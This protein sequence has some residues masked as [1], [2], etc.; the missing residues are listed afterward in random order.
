[1][2]INMKFKNN[3][4]CCKRL[5]SAPVIVLLLFTLFFDL[6]AVAQSSGKDAPLARISSDKVYKLKALLLGRI[7][8]HVDWVGAGGLNNSSPSFVLS[9]I[10]K[11]PFDKWLDTIYSARKKIKNKDVQ[12]RYIKKVEEIG[13]SHILFIAEMS[14]KELT[15][16]LDYTK[17]KPILTIADTEGYSKRGVHINILETM[18]S[19]GKFFRLEINEADAR[20]AGIV[21]RKSMLEAAN[22][23]NINPYN[24]EQEKA[25]RLEQAIQ[26]VQWTDEKTSR[27]FKIAVMG[28]NPIF[29]QLN[30]VFKRKRVNNKRVIVSIIS[31]VEA[32]GDSD[33][34]FISN[35]ERARLSSILAYTRG[36]PILTVGDTDGFARD[37]VHLNFNFQ[38]K[39]LVLRVNSGEADA[40]GLTIDLSSIKNAD[41]LRT[42]RASQ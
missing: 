42:R 37:G 13:G 33:V 22:N 5:L 29:S 41:R 14:R 6:T 35:S 11:N 4:W 3:K 21:V 8:K 38:S 36:K 19:S 32:I 23:K 34:L 18:R 39:R 1:M 2:G 7:P 30:K 27:T 10:G 28:P 20:R 16:I 15:K 12:L 25:Q 31:K 40:S 24:P 26:S 9:V 17:D